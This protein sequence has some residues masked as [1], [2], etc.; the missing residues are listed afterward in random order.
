MTCAGNAM[1][2]RG[3]LLR[4][5]PVQLAILGGG[6]L[7]SA[8]TSSADLDRAE[9]TG[10]VFAQEQ[11]QDEQKYYVDAHPY[12][13]MSL[14]QLIER[15]P[16]LKTIQAAADHDELATILA[17]TGQR[18]D[19]F[20]RNVVD[21][22]AHERITKEKLDGQRNLKNRQE[23]ENNYL[24]IRQGGDFWGTVDE[25]RMDSSAKAGNEA[26]FFETANF[27]LN[28]IYFATA[29][30]AESQ[31]LYL[32]KQQIDSQDTYV[33]A[34]A[35][36]PGVATLGVTLDKSEGTNSHRQATMLLQGIAWVDA[37]TFQIIRLRTDLLAPRRDM[38]LNSLTTTITFSAVQLLDVAKPLWLPNDA[39]S[40]VQF[41]EK[42]SA[43]SGDGELIY[44]NEHRYTKYQ[45][46]RVA[47][48]M[49]PD[50]ANSAPPGYVLPAEEQTDRRYYAHARAY[51]D[52]PLEEISKEIPEIKKVLPATEVIGPLTE[53]LRKTA[54]NVDDFFA[55]V[56][57][58]IAREE[59][60]QE[61]MNERGMVT[62][63]EQVKDSYLILRHGS[64]SAAH[65]DEYRM[66]AK[67]NRIED[68]GLDKGFLVTFGYALSSNYF[69]TAFQPESKFRY[70]GDEKIGSRDTYVVLFAQQPGVAKLYVTMNGQ[71]GA[72]VKMLMQGIAWVDKSNFQIIRMR[73]D[74]LAPRPEVALDRQSTELDFKEVQLPDAATPFWLPSEVKV[75]L[76][77]KHE[78][79]RQKKAIEWSY[80]N[81]HHYSEYRRYQVSVKMKT[82]Q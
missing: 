75:Y 17:K 33:M 67:G 22:T 45:S 50:L 13:E 72:G 16:E 60:K 82:P 34:F 43:G 1:K 10:A 2:R 40:V 62:G 53:I 14:D 61:R 57:D 19:E 76:R 48:K 59:I 36:K 52:E 21:V 66:D 77:F 42:D 20:F 46:F 65:I 25:Y 79:S 37:S 63:S 49:I 26:D 55:H 5:L 15:I 70:I 18:V 56:V 24:V 81:E 68:A 12:L 23:L 35:Q 78:D 9:K 7:C 4:L 11:N 32:G 38:N 74:L 69:S 73:T 8:M 31:F 28:E 29:R 80:K 3:L 54:V 39:Q 30:Q 44:R 71:R 27:A 47:A 41:G 51:V 6:L 58:L 64:G